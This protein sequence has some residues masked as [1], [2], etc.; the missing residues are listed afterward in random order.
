MIPS[1]TNRLLEAE[2]WTKIYQSFRNA[3]FKS[4]DFETLRR[5]MISYLRENYPE[6][7]NDYID[8]SEYVALIDLIAYLGQNLSFRID[9]NARENFIETAERRESILRLARLINYNAKRNIPAN[10]LLKVTSI[11]TTESVVD[12]NG[13]NLSNSI[14]G[15]NDPANTNWYQQFVAIINAAMASPAAFGKPFSSKTID[16]VATEQYRLATST[17]DVPVYAFTKSI[18]GTQMTFELVS[19]AITD[20]DYIYEEA[21]LP[22]NQL[23]FLFRNDN[24]GSGSVNTGFFLHF[25]QG[26]LTASNF[27]VGNPVP[28]ELIGVNV[29]DIN[30]TDVWLW[31]LSANTSQHQTLWSNVPSITGNN[32]I[33][34]SLNKSERNIYAVITRENDQIDLSFADGSFGNLP[35]GPFKLY[36]RQSNG[37]SYSIKPEQ[38][39]NISVQIPYYS[40]T[41]QSHSLTLVLS[42]QYSVANSVTSESNDDIKLKAPQAYY[43]QNRMITAEDYNIAPLTVNADVIKVKSINRVSSG[44]SKYFELSDVSGKY[45]KTNI[46]AND[47]ILYRESKEYNFDFVFGTR[48]EV[49]SIVRDQIEPIVLSPAFKSFY[50][51][52]YSRVDVSS[53]LLRW[54]QSNKTT[55]QSRG[56]FTDGSPVEIGT[57]VSGE[58][59]FF[60]PGALIKFAPPAGKYFLPN[61]KITAIQDDTTTS[62]KW[63]QVVG[64]TGDGSNSGSGNLDS[65]L[66]PVT[67]TGNIV[68]DGA[69]I[70]SAT[71]V[72]VIPK[73]QDVWSSAFTSEV[74]N[75]IFTKKNFGVSFDETTRDWY[76]ISDSNLDLYSDF[77]FAYQ[78]DITNTNQDSSWMMSFEWTGKKY[79]VRYR[80]TDYIFESDKETA[81]FIDETTKNYDFTTDSVIK[82]QIVVLDIN[83]QPTSSL[84]LGT[85]YAWQIDS[86]IVE[87]DGYVEPKKVL[88]SF[89]DNSDDGQIDDPDA[90]TNIV[91]PLSTSTQTG[92]RDKFVYFERQSDGL[93]YNLYSEEIIAYPSEDDVTSP[94]D[95]QLYYFYNP[96]I[97]VIKRYD[98]T[99]T[100]Y[101]TE[102]SLYART[103]RS[104]LK[105]HYQ[106]NSSGDRRIDPSKMNIIDVY[107]LTKTYDLE[108]RTWL[109]GG[110]SVEPLP[111]TTQSLEENYSLSLEPI[112][113]ISDEIIY[114]SARYK[115]LFGS[116]AVTPLQ[117]TF[118]AVRNPAR[119]ISDTDIQTRILTAIN[120]FFAIENWEFG[121]T[122]NFSELATYVMNNMTPDIVNFVVV[123][124]LDSGFGNLYEI[125]CQSNEIFVNGA[126][127]DDIQVIDSLT[128]TELKTTLVKI[129]S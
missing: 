101:T 100:L 37:L 90:F 29:N 123:P 13:I 70:T 66:G 6:D 72:S 59:S 104:D 3:D 1:T 108:Y 30:D 97:D 67:L 83:R 62:Y 81:F 10:G 36:Y 14:I 107:L 12:S 53:L 16:G 79:K 118:K 17:T 41:G 61:G 51:D 8:S 26:T 95:Q 48:N 76:I 92:F 86:A 28:N 114:H 60:V 64:V 87:P 56:Y 46:F 94:D 38:M 69:A 19:S 71:P 35:S 23:G 55:N 99:S 63:S 44:I 25:R 34:N 115:V 126:T 93:R 52:H 65:G 42:L 102:T 129:S 106:H 27:T 58:L 111:P 47:G 54:N 103:G 120:D 40:K 24:K 11:S 80:I 45:S 57:V 31:Q 88:V 96:D 91:A 7:F 122:F 105:I 4:Y 127:I 22:A 43:T 112:K 128:S 84:A 124:K 15:W 109:S 21:P 9:L 33:Y 18:N 20:K 89:Y 119:I 32:V 78:G 117:G 116:K 77:S 82:D 75:L 113:S 98:S 73:F 2:D 49:L 68:G 5:T 50:L 85:E 110:G 39:S 74:T 121:Q 125:A